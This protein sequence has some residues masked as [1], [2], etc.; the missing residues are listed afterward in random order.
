[1]ATISPYGD[2][3]AHGSIGKALTFR[4]FRGRTR[5]SQHYNPK[6]THTPGQLTQ[7]DKFSAAIYDLNRLNDQWKLFLYSRGVST[8]Q[9][10]PNLYVSAHIKERLPSTTPA[11][12]MDALE[13]M[14]LFNPAGLDPQS[15]K[16]T[17]GDLLDT[18]GCTLWN[19]VEG[20]VSGEIPSDI[21]PNAISPVAPAFSPVKFNNGALLDANSKSLDFTPFSLGNAGIIG[22]WFKPSGWSITAGIGTVDSCSMF[23]WRHPTVY[24]FMQAYFNSEA[25]QWF[26]YNGSHYVVFDFSGA[27]FNVADDELCHLAFA[28]ERGGINGG[29][30]TMEVYKNKVLVDSSTAALDDMTLQDSNFLRVGNNGDGLLYCR[31]Y[32]DNVK[33]YPGTSRLADILDNYDNEAFPGWYPLGYIY[34]SENIFH[35][36]VP[37]VPGPARKITIENASGNPEK[38]PFDYVLALHWLRL[39]DDT[40]VATIRLPKLELPAST[41]FDLY[42]TTDGSVY[43]DPALTQLACSPKMY[44]AKTI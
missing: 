36:T 5:L 44:Y 38:I 27:G 35:P 39:P 33:V 2:S 13:N 20:I 21:G 15:I 1:M 40:G 32:I 24:N 37:T 29:P 9:H 30:N 18:Y 34:D 3:R 10:G 22:F 6:I 26:F 28:W 16:I 25:G 43:W 19:K 4:R 7:R 31:S 17:I 41:F 23:M 42:I 8:W 11:I 12:P 14:V